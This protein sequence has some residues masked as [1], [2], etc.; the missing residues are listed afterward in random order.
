MVL[1]EFRSKFTKFE[2]NSW[3]S[4]QAHRAVITGFPMLSIGGIDVWIYFLLVLETSNLNVEQNLVYLGIFFYFSQKV[5][6]VTLINILTIIRKR[7]YVT[8][9]LP[10]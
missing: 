10:W 8:E 7:H 3:K 9:Q 5:V 4:S 1:L 2:R 6:G